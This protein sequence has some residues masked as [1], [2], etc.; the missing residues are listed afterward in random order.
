MVLVHI[1]M[2]NIIILF[3]C[4][5]YICSAHHDH[6]DHD[7]HRNPIKFPSKCAINYPQLSFKKS[8]SPCLVKSIRLIN[9]YNSN[10]KSFL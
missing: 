1:D 2:T 7:D 3:Y 10:Y 9:L 4:I 5:L 8:P 6:D